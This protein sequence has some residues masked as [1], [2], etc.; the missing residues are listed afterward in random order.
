MAKKQKKYYKEF[1]KKYPISDKT[2]QKI[3]SFYL[4]ECPTPG[5]SKRA[6][7]FSQLGWRGSPQFSNLKKRLL[8]ASTPSL[9]SNYYPCKKDDLE[10]HFKLVES[11]SPVDEYCVFLRSDEKLV[12]HSL[13]SAIR[14]A[15]AHGSFAIQSFK[16]SNKKNLRIYFFSNY[17]NYL[18][19]EIILQ[20]QTLLN[21]IHILQSGYD[22]TKK[23]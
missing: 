10:E 18:K 12:M 23:N 5:K 11:V 15:F 3:L 13:F 16:D 14:N 22:P 8:S 2:F 1:D 20:E 7:D 21:W 9:Q 19:A 4:F 17:D 6:K